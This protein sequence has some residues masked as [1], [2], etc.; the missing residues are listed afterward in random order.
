MQAAR[1]AATPSC[2]IQALVIIVSL[3]TRRSANCQH[4]VPAP[5]S[6][7]PGR[8]LGSDLDRNANRRRGLL[9][10]MASAAGTRRDRRALTGG[11]IQQD[12]TRP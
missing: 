5:R 7:L 2:S 8:T 4:F 3:S 12:A 11:G 10:P 6:I 9:V 1:H